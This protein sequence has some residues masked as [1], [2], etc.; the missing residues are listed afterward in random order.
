MN[1]SNGELTPVIIY[2]KRTIGEIR[3]CIA[4]NYG[5]IKYELPFINA[6][7]VEIPKEKLIK[8][9]QNKAVASISED[10]IVSKTP[11]YPS[12]KTVSSASFSPADFEPAAFN[13]A[14]RGKGVGV[15]VIDTGVTP[16][17]DL[18]KPENRIIAFKDL[19][20]N[21]ETPYDDDGHGTHVCGIIAG[22]GYTSLK[23]MGTAPCA[24][25]IAIKALDDNGNGT[26]SDILAALQ[27]SINHRHIYNIRVINLSLGIKIES[28]Y[29]DDP[30][31]R[32]ANAAVRH[33]ISVITAAGNNGP[34][35]CTINSPGVSPYVITVGAADLTQA[36]SLGGIKVA[37]FSSR[38]PTLA[39]D[40]KPD[41][42]APGVE[43]PSLD[44]KNPKGYAVQSGTSMAAPVV[45]GAAACLYAMR[46]RL[47]PSQV[48]RILIQDA[49]P[50]KNENRNAQGRGLLNYKVFLNL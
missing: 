8:L 48:K 3:D 18:I 1:L 11:I 4:E 29:D 36:D 10:A 6:V 25:I 15:A 13:C 46:P 19:I 5:K 49:L 16:H 50:I 9:A 47:T 35:K 26:E 20:G 23:F 34:G 32:G 38:G 27:W 17:Y 33:G 7:S 30:L 2:S 42:I 45:S 41:L 28:P 22:N 44:G 37:N 12:S 31:V 40:I 21:K 24:N 14:E 39:G 43:I